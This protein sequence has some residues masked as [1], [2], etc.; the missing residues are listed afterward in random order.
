LCSDIDERGSSGRS[1]VVIPCF[2]EVHRLDIEQVAHLLADERTTVL[3]VDDGSK[4]GTA[5][6]LD[7]LRSEYLGR[8]FVEHFPNNRGKAEAVR[9]GFEVAFRLEPECVGYLDA[10]FAASASEYLRLIDALLQ[11]PEVNV[12]LGARVAL[13]GSRIER[14]P[15]RHYLGRIFGSFAS[16]ILGLRVYDTQCGAKVFRL[17]PRLIEAM[18]EPFISRWVFDVEILSRL[19]NEGYRSP[20]ITTDQFVEVPLREWRDIAGS[21]L[22]LR[23]MAR[24]LWDLL[25]IWLRR[26]R[27]NGIVR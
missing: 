22:Q 27:Q 3:F 14:S 23:D 6:L 11:S 18:S 9:H 26:R 2:N 12:V 17:E 10:D 16:A 20:P 4:D 24:S 5:E 19:T 25:A 21:N 15:V 1:V 7:R 13:L 8:V